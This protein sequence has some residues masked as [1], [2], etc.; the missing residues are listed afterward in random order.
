MT[1]ENGSMWSL[2]GKWNSTDVS[3]SHLAV[4]GFFTEIFCDNGEQD[5]CAPV[6]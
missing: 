6:K 1:F 2:C 4:T 3:S 5:L